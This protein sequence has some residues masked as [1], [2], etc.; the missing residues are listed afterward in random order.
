[1]HFRCIS[2]SNLNELHA[3]NFA[4]IKKNSSRVAVLLKIVYFESIIIRMK[5]II[6]ILI[7]QVSLVF[8]KDAGKIKSSSQEASCLSCMFHGKR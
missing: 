8:C 2:S 6:V 5:F 1:M 4:K 3:W 7:T